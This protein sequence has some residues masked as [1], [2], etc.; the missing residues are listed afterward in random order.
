MVSMKGVSIAAPAPWARTIKVAA[1]L[2]PVVKNSVS[3]DLDIG[4]EIIALVV[5]DDERGEIFNLDPPDRF[6]AQFFVLLDLDFF[7]AVEGQF[8][9]RTA[10]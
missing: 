3:G 6:H 5:N 1:V 10:D 9:G 2:G 4:E 8:G 7:D